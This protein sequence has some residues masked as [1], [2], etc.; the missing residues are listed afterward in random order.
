MNVKIEDVIGGPPDDPVA[1]QAAMA[2][3]Q[4][5]RLIIF[6]AA[7]VVSICAVI[8]NIQHTRS[9]RARGL[10]DIGA[11]LLWLMVFRI[12]SK[13]NDLKQAEADQRAAKEMVLRTLAKKP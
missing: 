4:R 7:V 6:C 9:M 10:T 12:G 1:R 8:M 13:L 2:S 5:Q 11:I 3:G